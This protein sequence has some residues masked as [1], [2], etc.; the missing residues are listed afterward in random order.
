M[1]KPHYSVYS[2]FLPNKDLLKAYYVLGT[3]LTHE[4]PIHKA[5]REWLRTLKLFSR[6]RVT[7]SD[8]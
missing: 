6:G 2:L 1:V 7:L 8:S 5:L 4:P 3:S